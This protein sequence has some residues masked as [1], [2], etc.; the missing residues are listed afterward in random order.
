M[1]LKTKKERRERERER[2]RDQVRTK[3]DKQNLDKGYYPREFRKH[4]GPHEAHGLQFVYDGVN[5]IV[6]L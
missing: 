1:P 2:E 6:Y 4:R 5:V 3:R